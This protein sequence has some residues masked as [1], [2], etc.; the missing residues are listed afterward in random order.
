LR[1][2]GGWKSRWLDLFLKDHRRNITPTQ[3]NREYKTTRTGAD[4][5]NSAVLPGPLSN[6]GL[7][8]LA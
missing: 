5:G 1:R 8:V 3:L 4:Y 7:H 2:I 6:L